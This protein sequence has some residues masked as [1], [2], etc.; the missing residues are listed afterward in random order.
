VIHDLSF[1]RDQRDIPGELL[2]LYIPVEHLCQTPETVRR[3][4]DGFRLASSKGLRGEWGEEQKKKE[5]RER[6]ERAELHDILAGDWRG[7]K[8]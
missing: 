6:N 8:V 4:A 7:C 5:R 3:H 2:V 1:P